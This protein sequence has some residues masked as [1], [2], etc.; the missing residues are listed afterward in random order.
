MI[1]NACLEFQKLVPIFL[2]PYF[3]DFC[4]Y[5]R[6]VEFFMMECPKGEET[7]RGEASKHQKLYSLI[8]PTI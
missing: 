1:K 6:S 5:R 8:W 2:M 7:V 3:G 4:F